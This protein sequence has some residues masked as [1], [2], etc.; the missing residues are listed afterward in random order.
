MKKSR[1]IITLIVSILFVAAT[2][3]GCAKGTASE[4]A[5]LDE[6]GTIHLRVN[7]E[8]MIQYDK[9]G[10]VTLIKG[11]MMTAKRLSR[12]TRTLSAKMPV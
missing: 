10:L 8:I 1:Q 3:F 12:T 11:K 7:P 6:I 2:L 4:D 5:S 9:D